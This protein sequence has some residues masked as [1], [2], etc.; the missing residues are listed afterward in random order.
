MKKLNLI[1]PILATMFFSCTPKDK[2]IQATDVTI[3]ATADFDCFY[4]RR[5]LDVFSSLERVKFKSTS[6]SDWRS[7]KFNGSIKLA[8]QEAIVGLFPSD[9]TTSTDLE[10]VFI[11][12]SKQSSDSNPVVAYSKAIVSD[13]S[14]SMKFTPLTGSIGITFQNESSKNLIIEE[15]SIE[16]SSRIFYSISTTNFSG[17]TAKNS[18]SGDKV[19]YIAN[20]FELFSHW[21]IGIPVNVFPG[22]VSEGDGVVTIKFRDKDGKSYEKFREVTVSRPAVGSE[23]GVYFAI[24]DEMIDGRVKDYK[25]VYPKS[26]SATISDA[27]Y[28]LQKAIESASGIT[29]AVISDDEAKSEFEI[30]IGE[31]SRAAT[32]AVT[33]EENAYVVKYDGDNMVVKG[34]SDDQTIAALYALERE[35]LKN[36][37]Y[38]TQ[39]KIAFTTDIAITM[40][41]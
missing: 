28:A 3:N 30:L 16:T 39:G 11:D 17:E 37:K 18:L 19:T 38:V 31:T 33:C 26:A 40:N 9:L 35:V 36:E 10:K 6:G 21:G 25:I 20:D 5:S 4:S 7:T 41:Y 12:L 8:A 23:T 32:K 2:P 13:N 29:P 24:T 22:G 1:L 15:F 34:S 14:A 27:A